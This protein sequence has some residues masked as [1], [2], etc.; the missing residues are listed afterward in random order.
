MSCDAV[1]DSR[2]WITVTVDL[3]EPGHGLQTTDRRS[4]K[5]V[6]RIGNGDKDTT[7]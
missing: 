7:E 2:L 4:I 1:A 3:K 5:A 6:K